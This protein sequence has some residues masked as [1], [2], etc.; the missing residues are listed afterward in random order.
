MCEHMAKNIRDNP[1]NEILLTMGDAS[2]SLRKVILEKN[3]SAYEAQQ[4]YFCDTV[5]GNGGFLL[6]IFQVRSG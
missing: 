4:F 2:V 6:V 1:S 5:N 3:C